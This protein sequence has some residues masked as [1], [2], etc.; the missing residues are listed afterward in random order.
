MSTSN[1][2]MDIRAAAPPAR[3]PGR[4]VVSAVQVA[5]LTGAWI[6]VGMW[7]G[8]DGRVYVAL[9]IPF[10]LVFQLWVR[11]LPVRHLWVRDGDRF[12]LD[13]R[14]RAIA[15]VLAVYPLIALAV[16]VLEGQWLNAA[17]A[18]CAVPGALAAAYAIRHQDT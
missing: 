5:V 6:G 3:S 9:G 10:V 17:M 16:F 14:G 12:A 13:R 15:A 1:Q 4:R 18:G 8:L 7:L 11:R 2:L